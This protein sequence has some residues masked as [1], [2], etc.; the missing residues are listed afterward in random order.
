MIIANRT[1]FSTTPSS[2]VSSQMDKNEDVEIKVDL[3]KASKGTSI[4]LFTESNKITRSILLQGWY[5]NIFYQIFCPFTVGKILN[6]Q[7]YRILIIGFVIISI[8]SVVFIILSGNKVSLIVYYFIEK[9]KSNACR[10]TLSIESIFIYSSENN[11][12]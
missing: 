8:G 4:L 12:E 11:Q 9:T 1:I 6:E 5:Q 7:G 2:N 10:F 3:N